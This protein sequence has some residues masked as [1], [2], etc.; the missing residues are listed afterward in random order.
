MTYHINLK[1]LIKQTIHTLIEIYG[2]KISHTMVANY[3]LTAVAVIKP[4]VDTYNYKPSTM[5]SADEPYIKVK[6]I[7]NYVLI[8]MNA[9]KKSI[10][11]YQVSYTRIVGSC[12]LVMRMS[13]DKY[14]SIPNRAI[15]FIA[16]GYSTYPLAQQQ[17]ELESDM[18]FD[19]SQVIDLTNDDPVFKE[20]RDVASKL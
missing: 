18:K 15:K 11:A 19:L 14:K 12:I 17:F 20:F 2:I 5:L 10:L 7:K 4:F 9:S 16:D 13:F 3:T 6:C 8:I 1:L